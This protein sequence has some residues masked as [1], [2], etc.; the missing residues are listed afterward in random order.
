MTIK[1][2]INFNGNCK[3]AVQFYAKAFGTADPYIMLYGDM[4]KDE[5]HPL[6]PNCENLVTHACI[7]VCGNEIMFSDCPPGLELIVGNNITLMLASND[8]QQLSD[9]FNALSEGGQIIMP[10]AEQFWSKW[11]GYCIDKFGMGWQVNYSE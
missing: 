2:Y 6:P 8:K 1:A 3:E 5:A 11:Y 7:N 4:P 10:L 9:Y